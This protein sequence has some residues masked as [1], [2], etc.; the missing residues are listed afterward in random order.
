MNVTGWIRP[1]RYF[2]ITTSNVYLIFHFGNKIVNF[3]VQKVRTYYCNATI[4]LKL[5]N[6]IR[7]KKINRTDAQN[8]RRSSGTM[9]KMHALYG[10]FV[11]IC[12]SH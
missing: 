4:G 11:W 12:S 6:Y 10:Q 7:L 3:S 8:N 5:M 9:K 2:Q 1:V